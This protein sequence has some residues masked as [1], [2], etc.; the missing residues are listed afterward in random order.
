LGQWA[1]LA[2][3]AETRTGP[4]AGVAAVGADLTAFVGTKATT[5][6]LN[7]VIDLGWLK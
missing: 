1:S 3:A 4:L 6:A 7:F 2:L 5:I